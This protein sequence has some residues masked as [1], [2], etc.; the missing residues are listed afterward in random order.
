[1]SE[2]EEE[3]V[4]NSFFE[5]GESSSSVHD[6]QYCDDIIGEHVCKPNV[7]VQIIPFKG[8]I[9]K[10]LKLD[11]K[12]YSEYAEIGGFDVRLSTQSRFDNKI[13]KKKHVICNR[14]GKHKKKS[15]DT[16]GTSGVRRKR[17]SNSRAIG[18]QAKIIFESVYGTPH[19]KVFQFDELHNHPLE[20]RS[21]L[22]KRGKC[23]IQKK[24]LLCA[25]EMEKTYYAEF[26]DVISFDA[27]FRTNK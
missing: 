26:G 20:K 10:S 9:L 6:A 16:L 23:H 3:D 15:C 24:S 11:I 4:E 8:L 27:T 7:L 17:N 25:D 13:I 2:S 18:C 22:K 5:G 21:D 12:M 19:Y 14:G 1:M